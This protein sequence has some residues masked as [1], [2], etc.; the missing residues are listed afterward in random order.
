MTYEIASFSFTLYQL[1]L[2]AFVAAL[3]G[4]AKTGVQGAGM[5]AVPMLALVFG[6]KASTGVMLPILIFAD[7]FGVYYYN[8][9]ANWPHLKKLIPFAFAGVILGTVVGGAINETV[10]GYS[11]VVIIFASLAIM[12]WRERKPKADI[13]Q[14]FWFVASIG[15]A[16]GFTTMVGNLAGP[17]MALYL[18]SM[19]LPKNQFIGTAA[20]FF[21][22]I[23]LL[24]VP[25]HIWVWETITWDTV[26]LDL[27]LIPMIAAGAFL[28]VS[29][30]KKIPEQGFRWFVIFMTAASAVAMML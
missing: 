16:G 28:G 2:L 10:F 19:K 13:P 15:I 23:N 11:M 27:V 17:V 20:W 26:T 5:I 9:H 7:L 24:K 12:V 22:I 1:G 30:V 29:I 25:F 14:S 4:M 21:L 3:I 6:A 8:K 18:L